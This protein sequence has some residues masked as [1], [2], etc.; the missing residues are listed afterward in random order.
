MRSP[1][2]VI[3]RF[4]LQEGEIETL[5]ALIH[6][7][8]EKEVRLAPGFI[9]SKIYRNEEGTVLINY[10]TWESSDKYRE[11]WNGVV[12]VSEISKKIQA[13]KPQINQVFEI[14]L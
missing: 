4:E 10:A 3:V 1:Y 7:Y 13:F 12:L 8:F 11:F 14:P 6:E 5:H 9:S 2:Y